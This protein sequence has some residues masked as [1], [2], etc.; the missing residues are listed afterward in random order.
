MAQCR[1]CGNESDNDSNLCSDCDYATLFDELDL[2]SND[3][4]ISIETSL[5]DSELMN[6][7]RLNLGSGINLDNILWDDNSLF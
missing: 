4:D 5:I 1:M 7:P 3:E 6:D 2:I